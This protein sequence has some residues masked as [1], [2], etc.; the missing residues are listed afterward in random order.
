MIKNTTLSGSPV[1]SVE[2]TD[3][4]F[5]LK[6]Y[7]NLTHFIVAGLEGASSHSGRRTY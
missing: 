6:S 1:L 2:I 4:K 3:E 7:P 5:R